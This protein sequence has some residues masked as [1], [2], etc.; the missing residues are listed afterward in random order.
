MV[1]GVWWRIDHDPP[2]RWTWL[3]YPSPRNRF[4]PVSGRFRAR[5][6]ARTATAAARERFPDRRLTDADGDLRLIELVG[7]VRVLPLT[8][9][10]SLDV[11]DD[12]IST[13]RA[14][15]EAPR[16]PA[17]EDC[18]RLADAV[19]DWFAP[20]PPALL[21]RSRRLPSSRNVA[22]R[23]HSG[24]AAARARPLREAT[25]L[26]VHLVLRHGFVVPRHWLA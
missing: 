13:G 2:Q 3:P 17:L 23:D 10:R 5:Y 16:D 24:L 9:Q 1:P 11:L 15:A 18:W 26:L 14:T 8:H 4:D 6:A 21:Y 20:E 25:A 22:F 12:R 7:P 19:H